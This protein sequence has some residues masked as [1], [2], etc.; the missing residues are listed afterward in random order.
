[1]HP[2]TQ[3]TYMIFLYNA[4]N[5]SMGLFYEYCTFIRYYWKKINIHC[6][7]VRSQLHLF[8]DYQLDISKFSVFNNLFVYNPICMKLAS[9]S[10]VLEILSFWLG[11]TVSDPFPLKQL[12][13][14]I[15]EQQFT[16]L[17][18]V[19]N[20]IKHEREARV[21]YLLTTDRQTVNYYSTIHALELIYFDSNTQETMKKQLYSSDSYNFPPIHW[22]NPAKGLN[23][24]QA[25]TC[26]SYIF[27][28][29]KWLYIEDDGNDG[30][31]KQRQ[32]APRHSAQ[33]IIAEQ[34][35]V[36]HNFLPFGY[37]G[38]EC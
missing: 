16:L 20:E 10:L 24:T 3:L 6:E 13:Q 19:L 9:N 32:L 4:N 12:L 7:L 26:N 34:N 5:H 33:W 23:V 2:H 36:Q 25:S 1:M 27:N 21:M 15:A 35:Y 29:Q 11:L 31:I 37:I 38:E 22:R 30:F 8:S 17:G 28:E 18:S 14:W